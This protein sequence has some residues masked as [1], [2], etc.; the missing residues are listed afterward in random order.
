MPPS[1][2]R[3]A[4][5][6]SSAS[7]S[8][9][10]TREGTQEGRPPVMND[11]TFGQPPAELREA[12]AADLLP[13]RRLAP[14]WR[15]AL[16]LAPF[17]GVLLFAAPVI[18]QFRDLDALGWTL[19]WGASL[20]QAVAGVALIAA[21]LRE[22]VPGRS[23]S[24]SALLLIIGSVVILVTAVTVASWHASPVTLGRGWLTVGLICFAA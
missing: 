17:A 13:V 10:N 22:S 24:P 18:F 23:W 5:W 1:C 8:A 4:G 7:S 12:I 11:A 3:A 16:V 14:P 19:A 2:D 21:A 20:L 9:S 6:A 15:R